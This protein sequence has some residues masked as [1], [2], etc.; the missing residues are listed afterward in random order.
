MTWL[1]HNYFLPTLNPSTAPPPEASPLRP[2][3]PVLKLYKSL[4]KI[5]IRDASLR[6][7]YHQE[8]KS[9]FK[10]VER[11]VAEATVAANVAGGDLGWDKGDQ[12]SKERW[13]LERLCDALMEKGALVPLSKKCVAI[14]VS[15]HV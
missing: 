8:I 12:S 7:Q 10:D 6:S 5:V 1:L 3:A 9:V 15:L 13:A 14:S 11:W 2:L 4:Q